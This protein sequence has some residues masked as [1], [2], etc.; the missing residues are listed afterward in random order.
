M[1]G[2]NFAPIQIEDMSPIKDDIQSLDVIFRT[3]GNAANA[4]RPFGKG[5]NY[6]LWKDI[7]ERF[8]RGGK[9]FGVTWAKQRNWKK[10][11]TDVFTEMVTGKDIIFV[12]NLYR[13]IGENINSIR[14]IEAGGCNVIAVE[15]GNENYLSLYNMSI[16]EYL[17]R[18]EP[19]KGLNYK[20]LYQ[21][22]GQDHRKAQEWDNR[23]MKIGSHFAAH[24]YT[25]QKIP[26]GTVVRDLKAR[27]GDVWITEWNLLDPFKKFSNSYHAFWVEDFMSECEKLGIVNC[28]HN[29]QSGYMGL[30]DNQFNARDHLIELFEK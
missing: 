25:D 9:D 24:Y 20:L 15:L 6:D 8:F 17:N 2:L 27:Y 26:A 7:I 13:S 16:G 1:K 12:A 22:T 4:Y 11:W 10:N 30:W 28:Y 18:C 19:F 5:Y 3:G 21:V 14:K 29:V 23:V